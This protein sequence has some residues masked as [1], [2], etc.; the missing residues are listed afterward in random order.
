VDRQAL[1]APTIRD[2]EARTGVSE[3]TSLIEADVVAVWC[4]LL[5]VN[6]VGRN[7]NFFSVGGT[8]LSALQMLHRIKTRFGVSITVRQF[9]DAP[10]VAGVAAYLEAALA[11]EVATL[12]DDEVAERLGDQDGAS[13]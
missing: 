10:T 5:Q 13:R 3:V 11:A 12:S 2:R 4:D 6:Q 7:Q 8:S 1:P 9:F